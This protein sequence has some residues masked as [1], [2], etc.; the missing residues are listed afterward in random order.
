MCIINKI[1][2]PGFN[3]HNLSNEERIKLIQLCPEIISEF[4]NWTVNG[5]FYLYQSK[6][7]ELPDNL[8]V[9]GFVDLDHSS[10]IKIS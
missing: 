8:T 6:I 2:K 1:S 9:N 7:T 5:D 3:I 4:D 10:L